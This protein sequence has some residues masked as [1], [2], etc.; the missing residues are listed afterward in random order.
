M[1]ALPQTTNQAFCSDQLQRYDPDRY[2]IALFQPRR[3][4]RSAIALATWNLELARAR[5]PSG[6]QTIGLMRLQWHR[7]ALSEIVEGRPR[8]HPVIEELAFAHRAG[9]LNAERLKK[10][11]DARER[12][13]DP[14]PMGNIDDLESYARA[15]NGA[16]HAEL[17]QDTPAARAAEDAGTSF[18]LIGIARSESLNSARGRP[19][20]PQPLDQNLRLIIDRSVALARSTAPRGYQ[21][22]MAPII[23][24]NAYTKRAARAG[25]D[26]RSPNMVKPD[27][28]RTLRMIFAR[29]CGRI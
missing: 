12:D 14:A 19:W 1:N 2:L 25:F 10:I 21:A 3:L 11:V 8:H 15:T 7:D 26:T 24:A 20:V 27:P 9:M 4:R 28:N 18:A 6:E 13:I 23:L 16:L 5:P 22:A 17:W 29:L